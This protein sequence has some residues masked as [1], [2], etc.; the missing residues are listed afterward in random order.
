M[1]TLVNDFLKVEIRTKGAELIS[2]YHKEYEIE[3]IWQGDAEIWGWHAPNLFPVVGGCMNDQL[4]VDG[5]YFQMQRHGFARHSEFKLIENSDLHAKFSLR[6]N[7]ATLAVYPYHFEFQ[8]LYDLFEE[9]LRMT[10][11]VINLDEKTIHFSVGGHPAFNA[12]FYPGEKQED[13]FLEFEKEERLYT[14][15]LSSAGYFTGR[16]QEVFTE[17]NRLALTPGLFDQDALVFKNL[18]STQV[19]LKSRN[20]GKYI[21]VKFP[22]FAYLG[23]WAK[24]GA[25]FVCIEPWLGCAD[26]EGESKDIKQKEAIQ[27]VEHGHVFEAQFNLG[28]HA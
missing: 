15:N 24:P 17:G 23:I 16:T 12:P 26:S 27:Q 10:Y 25:D 11:K 7:E 6:Y 5:K 2:V 20:H 13:Y 8:V 22:Q 4:Q 14:H 21:T 28:F 9:E 1:A 19:S 18:T 3:H